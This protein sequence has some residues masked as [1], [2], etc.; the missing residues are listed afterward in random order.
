MLL[1]E[2]VASG[3]LEAPVLQGDGSETNLR[4]IGEGR[5]LLIVF[6]RHFGCLGCTVQVAQLE[7]RLL[8]LHELGF[9]TVFVGS[10]KAE[11][12]AGFVERHNLVAKKFALVVDPSL[13]IYA[14]AMLPRKTLGGVGLRALWAQAKAMG[15]GFQR[16]RGSGDDFQQGGILMLDEEGM[17]LAYHRNQRLGDHMQASD[18]VQ[19]ALEHAAKGADHAGLV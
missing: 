7:G 11:H 18:I 8:Q 4:A 17:V 12:I 14:A 15:N 5:P 10:G 19:V 2:K 16:Y 9:Q 13:S 6:L 3:V 1:G